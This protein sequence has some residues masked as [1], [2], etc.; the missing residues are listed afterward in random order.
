MQKRIGLSFQDALGT[1][2][3]GIGDDTASLYNLR[4]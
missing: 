3:S 4:V 2:A 1:R